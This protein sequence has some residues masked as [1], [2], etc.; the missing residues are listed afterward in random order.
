MGIAGLANQPSRQ[1][2]VLQVGPYSPF[3][4]LANCWLGHPAQSAILRIAGC[5]Y[6]PI[7]QSCT[8]LVGPTSPD[9]NEYFC[10]AY[11]RHSHCWLGYPAYSSITRVAGCSEKLIIAYKKSRYLSPLLLN[12]YN[13]QPPP[14]FT[15]HT[16]H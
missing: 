1:S 8:L 15:S 3:G 14:Q 16:S 10:Q 6:Q 7:R 13:P 11:T 5:A 4:Y 12:G 9:V 2:S